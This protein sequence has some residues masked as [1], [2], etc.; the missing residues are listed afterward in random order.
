MFS[1][2]GDV[3]L[4]FF[5]FYNLGSVF[6]FCFALSIK[7]QMFEMIWLWFLR[8]LSEGRVLYLCA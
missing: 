3:N 4:G 2:M 1:F 8:A 6:L 7:L 5:A